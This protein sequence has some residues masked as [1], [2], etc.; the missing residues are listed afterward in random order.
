MLMVRVYDDYNLIAL[1]VLDT[2]DFEG[3]EFSTKS[4]AK[5]FEMI[6]LSFK[7]IV[8][9]L[10]VRFY[11][12]SY[13][14]QSV[15]VQKPGLTGPPVDYGVILLYMGPSTVPFKSGFCIG[16]EYSWLN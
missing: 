7:D 4:R 5:L 9:L 1:L 13:C 10:T 6:G 12:K 14:I 8:C 16:I 2:D 15:P 3:C 11:A